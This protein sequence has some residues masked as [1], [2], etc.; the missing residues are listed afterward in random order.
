MGKTKIYKVIIVLIV[1]IIGIITGFAV[2]NL[3]TIRAHIN[4]YISREL[5]KEVFDKVRD[6]NYLSILYSDD[7]IYV[8][9]DNCYTGYT[10]ILVGSIYSQEET[11]TMI[12]NYFR[13][14]GWSIRPF[15]VD[16]QYNAYLKGNKIQYFTTP[17]DANRYC[18]SDNQEVQ[19]IINNNITKY[20]YLLWFSSEVTNRWGKCN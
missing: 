11:T 17:C 1:I 3:S 16:G 18:G 6:N 8:D 19:N 12:N 15:E 20:K 13:G 9:K 2:L 10:E 5:S 14:I 4:A 7:E